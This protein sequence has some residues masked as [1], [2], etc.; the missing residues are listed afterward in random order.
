MKKK[1]T[2]NLARIRQDYSYFVPEICALL[3]THKNTVHLW[4][5]KGLPKNDDAKPFLIHGSELKRFLAAQRL[6]RKHP[7]NAEQFYCCRCRQPR[8]AW[9]GIVDVHL[10]NGKVINLRGLCEQCECPVNKSS[11][12]ENLPVIAKTFNIQTV[13]NPHIVETLPP[14]VRCYLQRRNET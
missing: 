1:R 9:G 14:S 8:S 11:S 3:G 12:V 6:S 10:R 4:L 7:C 2:F 5:R 13:H